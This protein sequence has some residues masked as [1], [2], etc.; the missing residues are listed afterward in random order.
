MLKFILYIII[1]KICFK[2]LSKFIISFKGKYGEFKVK[3]SLYAKDEILLNDIYLDDKKGVSQIDHILISRKGIFSI[4]TKNYSQNIKGDVKEKYWKS[5]KHQFYNPFF[6]NETH[7]MR[8]N[9]ICNLPVKNIVIFVGSSK[10]KIKNNNNNVFK[11]KEFKRFLKKQK[12]I[13]KKEELKNIASKIIRNSITDKKSQKEYI[14]YV[15]KYK[16]SIK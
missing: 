11:L 7:K 16:K 1:A 14:E 3:K 13:Y 6:Q 12:N 9:R 10:L 5:G 15:K 8:I 2:I 4:E